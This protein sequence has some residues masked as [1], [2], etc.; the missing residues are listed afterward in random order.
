MVSSF[1]PKIAAPILFAVLLALAAQTHAADS[2]ATAEAAIASFRTACDG[3][4]SKT[5]PP[6]KLK[7]IR[8]MRESPFLMIALK[9]HVDVT[10]FLD[11]QFASAIEK[12]GLYGSRTALAHSIGNV[13]V[14]TYG[15]MKSMIAYIDA[16][17]GAVLCVAFIP[18]G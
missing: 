16:K 4:I 10:E 7:L 6:E 5:A 12:S 9:T 17:S 14:L 1:L 13:W 15:N 2:I 18:E 11:P 3:E 8:A